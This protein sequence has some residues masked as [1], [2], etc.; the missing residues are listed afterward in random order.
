MTQMFCKKCGGLLVPK[1]VNG[2]TVLVC[3][4]CGEIY[5]ESLIFEG[6]VNAK[7]KEVKV[8]VGEEY[9]EDL[10]VI[11]GVICPRCGN[12]EAYWWAKQTRS[13][14]EAP[15]IFYKCTKC[16]YVWRDYG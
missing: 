2:K 16:G 9:T 7:K 13:P 12:D 11:K 6:K 15:T 5:E 4:N 10:P 3:I 14:D 1:E 8:I